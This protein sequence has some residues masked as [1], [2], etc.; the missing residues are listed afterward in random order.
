MQEMREGRVQSLGWED[1]LEEEMAP[2]SSALVARS[3][4]WLSMHTHAVAP[5]QELQVTRGDH[6]RF[7][8]CSSC[9][10]IVQLTATPC[11]LT[12]RPVCVAHHFKIQVLLFRWSRA[13]HWEDSLFHSHIPRGGVTPHPGG[14]T[15]KHQRPS[16]SRGSK[17]KAW[18]AALVLVF[19]GR[20]GQVRVSWLRID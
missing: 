8:M 9:N 14:H 11:P 6:C 1:P 20:N 18:T 15:G 3:Q 12:Q 10:W 13:N 17:R 19:T 5:G 7:L 4:T 2:H 16:G